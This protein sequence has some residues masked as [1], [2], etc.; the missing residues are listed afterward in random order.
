MLAAQRS[1]RNSLCD[2]REPFASGPRLASNSK[3]PYILQQ[4]KKMLLNEIEGALAGVC[5]IVERLLRAED[6]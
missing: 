4:Q 5:V 6:M 3:S 2:I 1:R